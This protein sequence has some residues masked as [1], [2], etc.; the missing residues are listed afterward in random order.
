MRNKVFPRVVHV[1]NQQRSFCFGG[2]LF[3]GVNGKDVGETN[4]FVCCG[5]GTRFLSLWVMLEDDAFCK[6]VSVMII[7]GDDHP[8]AVGIEI[9][10]T[11]RQLQT[12]RKL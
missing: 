8:G 11:W 6:W 7:G 3:S 10:R 4:V 12:E 5:I 2:E 9:R 1:K